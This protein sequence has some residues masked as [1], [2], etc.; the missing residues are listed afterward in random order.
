MNLIH[1]FANNGGGYD[2]DEK[3]AINLTILDGLLL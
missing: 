1:F 3:T 2:I